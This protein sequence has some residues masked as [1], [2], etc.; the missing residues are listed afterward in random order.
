M[1]GGRTDE[2]L[3]N[4]SI[5]RARA[6]AWSAAERLVRLEGDAQLAELHRIDIETKALAGKILTPGIKLTLALLFVRLQER[7]NDVSTIV[8]WL[9]AAPEVRALLRSI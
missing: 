5:H 7:G 6:A 1:L 8:G 3:I 2:K 4:F 9:D